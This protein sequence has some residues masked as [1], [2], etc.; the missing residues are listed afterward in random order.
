MARKRDV[1]VEPAVVHEAPRQVDPAVL[2]KEWYTLKEIYQEATEAA[3]ETADRMNVF[4]TALMDY[5]QI[6]VPHTPPYPEDVVFRGANVGSPDTDGNEDHGAVPTSFVPPVQRPAV[7]MSA[8]QPLA[9]D[10][11]H[12]D[13]SGD[14]FF[15]NIASTLAS[16][17]RGMK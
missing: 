10:T 8:T 16:I 2:V 9:V 5:F 12:V 7:E 3:R 15:G 11:A 14:E 6:A 17:T 13:R 1:V 4:R